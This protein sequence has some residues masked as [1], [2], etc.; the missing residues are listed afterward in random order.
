MRLAGF[1]LSNLKRRN[2]RLLDRAGDL[3]LARRVAAI[4]APLIEEYDR[5]QQKRDQK[6]K[7][8]R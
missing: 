4:F 5:E 7:E 1:D 2:R 3:E 6:A 8:E